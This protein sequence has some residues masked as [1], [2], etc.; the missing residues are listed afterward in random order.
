MALTDPTTNAIC[1]VLRTRSVTIYRINQQLQQNTATRILFVQPNASLTPHKTFL[2]PPQNNPEKVRLI[3]STLHP[4]QQKELYS[5]ITNVLS[6]VCSL[7]G[8]LLMHTES[9]GS[10]FCT[11][12]SDVLRATEE[13][14][15]PSCSLIAPY[16]L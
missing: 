11:G 13:K 8:A 3:L 6:L 5:W 4:A 12:I 7:Q 10:K 1:Q 9:L 2:K 15:K 14:P 16:W